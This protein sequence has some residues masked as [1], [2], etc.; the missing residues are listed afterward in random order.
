MRRRKAEARIMCRAYSTEAEAK[1][2]RNS[3]SMTETGISGRCTQKR[4]TE[5]RGKRGKE[6][7]VRG[8]RKAPDRL[9]HFVND[10]GRW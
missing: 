2:G 1:R 9:R 6:R 10:P 7:K 8:K 3:R 4:K 5:R